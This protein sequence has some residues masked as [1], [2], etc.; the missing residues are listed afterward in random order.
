MK[1]QISEGKVFC[2]ESPSLKVILSKGCGACY[3]RIDTNICDTYS[4]SSTEREDGLDVIFIKE[5]DK[6]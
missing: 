2:P 5:I 6:I 3:G 1:K 4:C